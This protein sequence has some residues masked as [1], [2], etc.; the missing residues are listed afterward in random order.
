MQ[1]TV[2]IDDDLIADAKQFTGI[3]ETSA[4]VKM[5][6]TRLVQQEAARRLAL[7]GGTEPDFR[8]ASRWRSDDA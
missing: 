4:V 3:Q 1:T 2:T 8:A 7:L 6:L 5:A